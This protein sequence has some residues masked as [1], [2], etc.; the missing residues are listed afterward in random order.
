MSCRRSFFLRFALPPGLLRLRLLGPKGAECFG[1]LL[2]LQAKHK[3]PPFRG[4][5]FFVT[6]SGLAFQRR[7]MLSPKP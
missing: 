1:S 7:S 5:C 2:Q 4:P 3:P 6:S